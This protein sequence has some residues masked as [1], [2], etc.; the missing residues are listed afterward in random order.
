MDQEHDIPLV[1]GVAPGEM[2][3]LLK[4]MLT[5]PEQTAGHR[6][7]KQQACV[8]ESNM[9]KRFEFKHS[10]RYLRDDETQ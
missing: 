8:E 6:E 3:A 1:Y 4:R 7:G 9:A 10:A 2:T 5:A